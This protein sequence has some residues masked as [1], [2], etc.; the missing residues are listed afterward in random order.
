MTAAFVLLVVGVGAALVE[1]TRARTRARVP[2]LV[3]W[4]LVSATLGL[5][6][7]GL[8]PPVVAAVAVVAPVC[9]WLL[10]APRPARPLPAVRSAPAAWYVLAVAVAAALLAGPPDPHPAGPLVVHVLHAGTPL[11]GAVSPAQLVAGL[12]LLALAGSPANRLVAA[13]L[14]A[15]GATRGVTPHAAPPSSTEPPTTE[16]SPTEPPTTRPPTPP[17][18]SPALR[19]GRWIGPLERI[20]IVV[21][22]L[23]GGQGALAALVAA[24]GVIRFPEISKDHSGEKAEQFLIG[25]LTSWTIAAAAAVLLA[26]LGA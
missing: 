16:P 5:L 7:L 1:A 3:A 9:W 19:G 25:S 17:A 11:A 20:L 23:S 13:L 24:K 2:V 6:G 15:A 22:A 26:L 14:E 8:G 12:G 10:A 18:T 4:A 21:L